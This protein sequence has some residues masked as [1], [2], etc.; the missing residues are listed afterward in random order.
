MI[1]SDPAVTSVIRDTVSS[2]V[3]ATESEPGVVFT[4]DRPGVEFGLQSDDEHEYFLSGGKHVGG[5]LTVERIKEGDNAGAWTLSLHRAR[6]PRVLSKAAV[7]AGLMPP[8][9]Y[10]ALPASLEEVTPPDFRYWEKT[11]A[12]AQG[13][14]DALVESGFFRDD[15]VRLVDGQLRH[16]TKKLFLTLPPTEIDK[17]LRVPFQS[18]G[19]SGQYARR[20]VSRLVEH[21][22]YVEP[23]CGSAAVLFAKDPAGEEVIADSNPEVVFAHQYIR[24][25]TPASFAALKR[26]DWT[27]SRAGF[28]RARELEPQSDAARFWRHVYGRLCTWGA[29]PVMTGYSTL[30][31]G[32]SYPLDDLWRFHER[33]KGVKIL[34]LD[35]RETLKRFDGPNT[36]FFIDPPYEDEWAHGD[37][38]PAKEIATAL[39]ALRGKW[40]VA[41]T[42]SA[43]ARHALGKVGHIFTMSFAEARHRGGLQKRPRLF[44]SSEPLPRAASRAKAETASATRPLDTIAPM[45]ARAV[46]TTLD[47][48][49]G[50]QMSPEVLAAG[51]AVE[52]AVAGERMLLHVKGDE[53]SVDGSDQDSSAAV[54]KALRSL[55]RDAILDG[56]AT[57]DGVFV[58][59][60]VHAGE[61]SLA[62]HPWRER[63]K[64]LARLF[65]KSR[66]PLHHLSARV[67]HTEEALRDAVQWASGE[68]HAAGAVIKLIDSPYEA[69]GFTSSWLLAR[70]G[71][72]E[73]PLP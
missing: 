30:H 41:Y 62:Q 18:W 31:E 50:E 60:V 34:G 70:P 26:F 73:Q 12:E 37:G 63:Q 71:A 47:E 29:K 17:A 28:E 64:V 6:L 32:Q 36:L 5:V 38:I 46:E 7:D 66:S 14:R 27:V 54:A 33:L 39:A 48:V 25:L 24:D 9:G 23:F 20:L 42:A 22:R 49:L 65:R 55:R 69:G 53:T 59:D 1:S 11:G 45:R 4:V 72:S 58:F 57:G 52:P 43:S 67:V 40:I 56:V 61:Q 15:S 10:S 44:A 21:E 13:A 35:W 3:G 19:G 51:V 16:V 68:P 8:D 2:S